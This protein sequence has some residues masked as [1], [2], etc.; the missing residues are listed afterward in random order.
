[1]HFRTGSPSMKMHQADPTLNTIH[2]NGGGFKPM[3]SVNLVGVGIALIVPIS[4][5]LR[6]AINLLLAYNPDAKSN[7]PKR[8]IDKQSNIKSTSTVLSK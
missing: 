4:I 3:L 2:L 5:D 8:A 1:M 6:E 7:S